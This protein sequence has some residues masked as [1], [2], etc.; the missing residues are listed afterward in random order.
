MVTPKNVSCGVASEVVPGRMG[1]PTRSQGLVP[2]MKGQAMEIE[3]TTF[4]TI[5]I[6]RKDL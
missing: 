5:T 6:E 1:L 3:R 2:R 4:G